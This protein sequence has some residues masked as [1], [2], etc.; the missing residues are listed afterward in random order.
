[1]RDLTGTFLEFG[2]GRHFSGIWNNSKPRLV[3]TAYPTVGKKRHLVKVIFTFIDD[4]IMIHV[5]DGIVKR[6]VTSKAR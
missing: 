4:D 2:C 3:L 6:I 5:R 1:M